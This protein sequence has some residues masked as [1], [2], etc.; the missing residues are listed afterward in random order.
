M[1]PKMVYGNGAPDGGFGFDFNFEPGMDQVEMPLNLE[2]I[3]DPDQPGAMR[4]VNNDND[5]DNDNAPGGGGV[6]GDDN[7]QKNDESKVDNVHGDQML[8]I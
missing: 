1:D 7:E 4:V 5:K 8:Q 3:E 6:G 2:E